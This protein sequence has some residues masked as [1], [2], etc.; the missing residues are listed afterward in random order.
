[1]II[2]FLWRAFKAR[3][4]NEKAEISALVSSITPGDIAVDVGTNKGSYLYWLSRAA[5]HGKVVAF[6]PQPRLAEYLREACAAACLSN[7]TVEAAGVSDSVGQLVLHVPG[8]SDSPSAS[9]ERA[10]A[11]REKCREIKVPVYSLDDYFSARKGR[12]SAIKIDVEGHE[13]AVLRGAK[14]IL[15]EDG[16]CLVLEC[17]SRHLT[18]GTVLDVLSYVKALGYNGHFVQQGKIRPLTEFDPAIHQRTTGER[19]WDSKDYCNN[20]ILRKVA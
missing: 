8:D 16:P 17:E 13:M 14:K 3:Y 20:F 4:R 6:E 5:A 11:S 10:V 2:R 7:I 18:Q 15:S 19:F 9:F 12:I 1:M